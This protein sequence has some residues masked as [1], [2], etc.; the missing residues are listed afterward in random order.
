MA[1]INELGQPVGDQ[2]PDD[3]YAPPYPTRKTLI[4]Q[5]VT[6]APLSL[7]A[8]SLDLYNAFSVDKTGAGWTY[9]SNGPYLNQTAFEQWLETAEISTDPM[10][11]VYICASTGN[12]IG[13]GSLMR[14]NASMA[15]IE[16]GNIRMSPLLQGTRMSTEVI[17]LKSKYIFGLGYRRFEWK[18]DHLNER[19]CRAAARLGFTFEGIFRKAMHYKGRSRDTA[20]FSITDDE[21]PHI[22]NAQ[23]AWL[24]P[25]N[26]NENGEQK[27]ALAY[28][29]KDCFHE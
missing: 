20:W 25:E 5:Y 4:G 9:M 19:S 10:F 21:W 8:H 3:W 26:F 15:T 1:T 12:A 11:F 16:V 7:E 28:F 22:C 24:A 17:H 29:Q 27:H 13:Y 23:T 2:L 14:I 18:C 6:V